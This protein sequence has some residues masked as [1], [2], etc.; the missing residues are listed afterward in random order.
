MKTC[1]A[2]SIVF[3]VLVSSVARAAVPP[4]PS[5]AHPRLFMSAAELARYQ[6]AAQQNGSAA[7]NLIQNCQHAIDTPGDFG[8]R[9]GVDAS[10]WPAAAVDCAFAYRVTGDSKFIAP[11]V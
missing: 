7:E 10:T 5:G 8:D 2:C 11:A 6:A 9:G 1:T 3:A 4:T